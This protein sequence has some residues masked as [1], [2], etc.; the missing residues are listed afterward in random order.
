MIH[1]EE[2]RGRVE[3]ETCPVGADQTKGHFVSVV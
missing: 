2:E 3:K 1:K